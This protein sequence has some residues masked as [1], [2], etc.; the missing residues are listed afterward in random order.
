M[1]RKLLHRIGLAR[2]LRLYMAMVIPPL[3]YE[4]A[5]LHFRGSFQS[6]FMWIPVVSLPPV[7]AG[8]LTSGLLGDGERA[9][10]LFRPLAWLMA[11]VGVAGTAFHVRG[12]GRQ[13]GG[14]TNW[15]Y[16]VVTG[17]PIPAPP[18][19]ALFGLIG[20]L[21]AAAPSRNE[22][23][24]LVAAARLVNVLSYPLLAV[25]AGYEHWK[26]GL[27]NKV[28]FTPLVLSP[29][30]LLVHLAAIL[31]LRP[32]RAVEGPLSAVATV[33]G[34]VGF[35]FH[36]W[37]VTHRTGGWSWQNLFYG[38]PLVAPLQMTGQGVLGLL[39]AAFGGRR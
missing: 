23:G 2:L 28:M 32:G 8:G 17:P 22:T 34:L 6:R 20:A 37:N 36:I 7:L 3:W 33:A 16:N 1:I 24:R 5:V 21:A 12:V 10:A 35:S 13:M 30:M 25:E 19:V 38:A 29:L 39:S 15:K 26:G 27:F 11:A 18:Q 14:F 31:R 4:I 9:R